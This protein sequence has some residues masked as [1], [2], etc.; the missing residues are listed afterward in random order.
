MDQ[1]EELRVFVPCGA[2]EVMKV[3]ALVSLLK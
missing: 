1:T 3:N 2:S